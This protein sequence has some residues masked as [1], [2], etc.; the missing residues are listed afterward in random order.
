M[1]CEAWEARLLAR[2]S[3]TAPLVLR[4]FSL[5]KRL[6]ASLMVGACLCCPLMSLAQQPPGGDSNKT[7]LPD[8]PK[9]QDNTNTTTDTTPRFIGYMTNKSIVFPAIAV[10]DRPLTPVSKFKLFL[11]QSISPPYLLVAGIA[12]A[13]DQARDA[14]KGYGQGWG[15]YGGRYGMKLARASSSSFFSSFL[16]ASTLHQDP[17]FFPQNRP[18]IWGSVKYS[19]NRVFIT[20]T[21]SG[22]DTFNTSGIVGTVAAEGLA[23]VYLPASEQTAARNCARI[24]TDLALRVG[25]N[26]FENYWPTLFRRLGLNEVKYIPNPNATQNP[27][28]KNN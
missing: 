11:N 23:N 28:P 16:L 26:M 25:V 19:V 12:A 10:S 18:T 1:D 2:R 15:A 20:R 22:I 27:A 7:S 5:A 9:P 6:S 3:A 24:G 14:P 8:S 17:R 13:F 21:D 4:S